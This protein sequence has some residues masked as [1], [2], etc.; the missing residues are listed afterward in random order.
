MIGREQEVDVGPMSGKSNVVFWLE[1]RGY[2]A[3][4]ETVDRI[5]AKAKASPCV[6]TEA[7]IL[8]ELGDRR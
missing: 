1:K 5:F 6:L 8:K 4:E 3:D 7:D 2:T